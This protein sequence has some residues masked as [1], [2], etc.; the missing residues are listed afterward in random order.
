MAICQYKKEKKKNRTVTKYSSACKWYVRV[1]RNLEWKRLLNSCRLTV[2]KYPPVGN[3]LILII[4]QKSRHFKLLI[5]V[6]YKRMFNWKLTRREPDLY[7]WH[8][9]FNHP[10]VWER[11][12]GGKERIEDTMSK[13]S[14]SFFPRLGFCGLW[15]VLLY[16]HGSWPGLH[17]FLTNLGI[18]RFLL[19]LKKVDSNQAESS[20]LQEAPG[21]NASF[22]P[23]LWWKLV[24]FQIQGL[25]TFHFEQ[26]WHGSAQVNWRSHFKWFFW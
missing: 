9:V 25:D 8:R 11:K 26:P 6:S 4:V 12:E 13:K 18:C 17:S 19:F 16:H 15:V 5:G 22:L 7:K 24:Y 1:V 21:C 2:C 20:R 10:G 3:S 23:L 14:A